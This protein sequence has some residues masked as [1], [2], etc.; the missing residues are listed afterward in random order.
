MLRL[1]DTAD[2][3]AN[4]KAFHLREF[5]NMLVLQIEEAEKIVLKK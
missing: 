1:I 4:N 3:L 2:L 5:R